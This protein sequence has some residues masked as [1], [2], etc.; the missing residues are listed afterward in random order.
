M[1]GNSETLRLVSDGSGQIVNQSTQL[2]KVSYRRPETWNFFFALRALSSSILPC[3]F[4]ATFKLTIGV[5]RSSVIIPAFEV[6][7]FSAVAAG[8]FP[9]FQYS[10]SVNG[11][12]RD[13][14]AVAPLPQNEIRNVVSQDIQLECNVRYNPATPGHTGVAE[15]HGY[16][17]PNVHV[18]PEWFTKV[19]LF[20]GAEGGQ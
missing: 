14:T 1:W 17:A 13:N 10:T 4:T 2:L 20:P 9:S 8:D 5:G 7:N 3:A 19:G 11:P 18:R 6:F 12:S 16:F 15:V